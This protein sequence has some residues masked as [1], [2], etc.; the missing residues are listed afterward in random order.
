MAMRM[1]TL[2]VVVMLVMVM[3][4][5]MMVMMMMKMVLSLLMMTMMLKW[6][7]YFKKRGVGQ[8]QHC[9]WET[10]SAVAIAHVVF[11]QT[12]LAPSAKRREVL[13]EF[14]FHLNFHKTS[15]LLFLW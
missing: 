9:I 11:S 6:R 4:M 8:G 1:M 5:T 7:R 15:P 12:L 2:M 3:I 14:R 13:V 10:C